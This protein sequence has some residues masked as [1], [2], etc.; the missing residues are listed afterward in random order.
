MDELER[1]LAVDAIGL[2]GHQVGGDPAGWLS[3]DIQPKP[4]TFAGVN[5]GVMV[6]SPS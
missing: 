6:P 1:L 5:R 2:H 3:R 4:V